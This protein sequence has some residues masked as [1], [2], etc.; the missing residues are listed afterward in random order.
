MKTKLT[1]LE[2]RAAAMCERIRQACQHPG[3]V[4]PV[5]VE[6]AKSS[7]WGSCPRVEYHGEK[8]AHA[9]GCGYCKLSTVLADALHWLGDTDEQRHSIAC[10]GGAGVGTVRARLADA[11]WQL[12]DISSGKTFDCFTVERIAQA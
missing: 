11:G 12:N 8:V 7:T 2:R 4:F 9:S 10:A 1:T 6:W 3:E 5:T